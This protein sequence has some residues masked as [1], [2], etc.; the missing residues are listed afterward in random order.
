MKIVLAGSMVF[1]ERMSAIKVEL[2]SMGH[3]VVMPSLTE[4]EIA[5]GKDTF[6][7]YLHS[8]G[9]IENVLPDNDIWKMKEEGMMCYKLHMDVSDAMLVCNFDKGGK[10]NRIGANVFLEMGYM[11]FLGKKIYVL[12]G[13]PYG[14]DKI[15]EVLGMRPVFLDGN[16]ELINT[17]K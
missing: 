3:S 6:T 14:D 4:D 1:L 7:E 11:F 8:V 9:G 16:I 15:E 5:T 17:I 12:Q 13:P 2:E 10:K